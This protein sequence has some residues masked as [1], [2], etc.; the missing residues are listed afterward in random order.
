[1]RIDSLRPRAQQADAWI[2]AQHP[3]LPFE[4]MRC[5]AIIRVK[6]RDERSTGL[7]EPTIERS[8]ET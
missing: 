4:P 6:S 3:D 7:V 2:V 1:M 8:D 5:R